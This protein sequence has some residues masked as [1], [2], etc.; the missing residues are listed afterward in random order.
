MS[1]VYL[2]SEQLAEQHRRGTERSHIRALHDREDR[3]K[4]MI[5]QRCMRSQIYKND[6]AA[7]EC[8]HQLR[9]LK[10]QAAHY[11]DVL[12]STTA[13]IANL[14]TKIRSLSLC[15]Q[16]MKNQLHGSPPYSSVGDCYH[17][18]CI[19]N[20]DKFHD[21]VEENWEKHEKGSLVPY[22]SSLPSR[23]LLL[24]KEAHPPD[25]PDQLICEDSFYDS[26]SEEESARKYALAEKLARKPKAD[27]CSSRRKRLH[28]PTAKSGTDGR[29]Y[30][31][32]AFD[33][34]DYLKKKALILPSMDDPSYLHTILPEEKDVANITSVRSVR[35]CTDAELDRNISLS[36]SRRFRKNL[37]T[38]I[39][40]Y[41]NGCTYSLISLFPPLDKLYQLFADARLALP[42]IKPSVMIGVTLFK[43]AEFVRELL[44]SAAFYRFVTT[45]EPVDLPCLPASLAEAQYILKDGT[46]SL[47]TNK[48]IY[49][50]ANLMISLHM[51][52]R[53]HWFDSVQSSYGHFLHRYYLKFLQ[54][55]SMSR[56]TVPLWPQYKRV[57]LFNAEKHLLRD[58]EL[59]FSFLY[60]ILSTFALLH[61][62]HVVPVERATYGYSELKMCESTMDRDTIARLSD[63]AARYTCTWPA[64]IDKYNNTY[65]GS[66]FRRH[67]SV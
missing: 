2:S 14:E 45:L 43:V 18:S 31:P 13:A 39:D 59:D 64:W 25:Q 67:K 41:L 19:L 48:T 54:I 63:G 56:V 7:N 53:A 8:M 23:P 55:N 9:G 50:T 6:L 38:V 20:P 22:N 21:D 24:W 49:N 40:K 26:V 52:I 29:S 62:L 42:A 36:D 35:A 10:L 66:R 44:T 4:Q 46:A 12:N 1:L 15:T 32:V 34:L 11:L 47:H 57:R 5:M 16:D 28:K 51:Y 30:D 33:E 58:G 27:T 61:E 37:L 17:S 60:A 65:I 3:H